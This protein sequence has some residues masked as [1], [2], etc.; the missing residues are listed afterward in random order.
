V[1]DA[2]RDRGDHDAGPEAVPRSRRADRRGVGR[3]LLA[4]CFEITTVPGIKNKFFGA[5]GIFLAKLTGSGRIWLQTMPLPILAAA[6]APYLAVGEGTAA[7]EGT[8]AGLGAGK[9]L[10]GLLSD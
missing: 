7:G 10:G 9:L 6:L 8:L 3:A 5:D 1:W 4:E 2:S